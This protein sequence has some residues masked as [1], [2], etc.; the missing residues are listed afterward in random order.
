MSKQSYVYI[1]HCKDL[2]T[3]KIGYSDNPFAR[4][5]QLQMGNSSELSIVSVFKGG[6]EEEAKLH[7][8]F[9]LNSVRGEW[10]SVDD[11]LVSELANYQAQKVAKDLGSDFE[12][13]SPNSELVNEAI[14]AIDRF[15]KNTTEIFVEIMQKLSEG[16]PE[17]DAKTLMLKVEE[18][19]NKYN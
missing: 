3:I 10:F 18:M 6:R 12:S 19:V 14:E 2:A 5:S 15:R 13:L 11:S 4:L 7:E 16:L 1:I 17:D 9:E 8:M